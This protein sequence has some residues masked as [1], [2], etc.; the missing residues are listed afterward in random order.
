MAQK[1]VR[2]NPYDVENWLVLLKDAQIRKIEDTRGPVFENL[3]SY[4]PTSGRFW[5]IYIEQEIKHCN[6]DTVERLFKRS[7]LKVLPSPTTE[8]SYRLVHSWHSIKS[9]SWKYYHD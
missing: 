6:Y 8:S 3:V 2:K 4:F 5:R 9:F 7:L 1:K